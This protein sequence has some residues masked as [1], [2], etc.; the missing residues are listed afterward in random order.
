MKRPFEIKKLKTPALVITGVFLFGLILY[1]SLRNFFLNQA[2]FKVQT[3]LKEEYGL[4]LFV[5][6]ASF[7]GIN[8]IT[9]QHCSLLPLDSDTLFRSER[10]NFNTRFWSLLA[11]NIRLN[12]LEM[13]NTLIHFKKTGELKNYQLKKTKTETTETEDDELEPESNYAKT[14]FGFIN[15]IFGYIPDEVKLSDY[16]IKLTED[17]YSIEIAFDELKLE[18]KQLQTIAEIKESEKISKWHISGQ[19]D[20]KNKTAL[21]YIWGDNNDIIFIPY[22]AKHFQLQTGFK[23]VELNL[24]RIEL[25]DDILNITGQAKANNVVVNHPKLASKDVKFDIA[26][27]HYNLLAGKNF[28]ALDSSSAITVNGYSVYPFIKVQN[29]QNTFTYWFNIKTDNRPAQDFLNALP[30][31]LF[32]NIKGMEAS[33][34]FSYKLTFMLDEA[35]PD[36]MIFESDLHKENLRIIKYGKA[37]LAKLNSDFIHYPVENGKP[38]RPILVSTENPDYYKLDEI[39]HYLKYA[40]LTNEDPSF[41]YHR[42]FVTDAFRQ[43]IVKN[44]KTGQFKRGASTISMQL[45]K[46]VFLTRE[47]TIARKLEEILLV[48]ILENNYLV[49]KERMFEVY[50]NI[51]E[52]GPNVYGIGEACKFYFNKKPSQ[53]TLSESL[54]LASIIPSPKKFMWRFD[55]NGVA[56][57]WL[58]K[59]FRF[60]ATKMINR[61]FIMPDDTINLSHHVNITGQARKFIIRNDSLLLTDSILINQL[62]NE[63]QDD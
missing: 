23:T 7:S 20:V 10:I 9:I 61:Q 44:I 62:E 17:D 35:R 60:I 39:S 25:D 31:G 12:R 22:L 24:S 1:F 46:N 50:L 33:G 5:K 47:K 21:L 29:N 32:E 53:L 14:A 38:V 30:E 4:Q 55:Y 11:G 3:K 51:I 57:N 26:E 19:A 34:N 42:G 43:S 6:K 8:N 36:E 58:E 63:Q 18:G 28:I 48:Y 40:V 54:F 16:I 41:F 37:N 2:I 27:V 45:M 49:S 59:S 15:K 56:R 52:W 13:N